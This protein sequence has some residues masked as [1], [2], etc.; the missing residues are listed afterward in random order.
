VT[1]HV[2]CWTCAH[3]GHGFDSQ[4]GEWSCSN[5]GQVVLTH[6]PLLPSSII[7][8]QSTGTDAPWS[9]SWRKVSTDRLL[10]SVNCRLTAPDRHQLWK[11]THVSSMRLYLTTNPVWHTTGNSVTRWLLDI[12]TR[13]IIKG[14][15]VLY[16][17]DRYCTTCIAYHNLY[18][19][20]VANFQHSSRHQYLFISMATLSG[21][22]WFNELFSTSVDVMVKTDTWPIN[23][24]YSN[25]IY[26]KTIEKYS[27]NYYLWR[28]SRGPRETA[29]DASFH[30]VKIYW[31]DTVNDS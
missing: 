26:K 15:S 10:A 23:E 8:Y 7:W 31:Q 9:W 20:N 11:P 5:S 12:N 17:H 16:S 22:Q 30:S 13:T 4:A 2:G 1:Q 25:V 14:L 21:G 3:N 19:R 29:L 18:V 28:K 24:Q 27:P 6:V